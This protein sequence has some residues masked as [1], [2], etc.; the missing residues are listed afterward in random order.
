MADKSLETGVVDYDSPIWGHKWGYQDTEFITLPDG[1]TSVTGSRY[2]I[3]G[4]EMPGFLPFVEEMLDVKLDLNDVIPERED[5]PVTPPNINQPFLDALRGV[6]NESQISLEDKVRLLHSHGQTTADEVYK[7]LYDELDRLCDLVVFPESDEDAA[8]LIQLA[9][10]HNVCLVPYG[11]GTSVSCALQLPASETRM[12]VVVDMRRMNQILWIDKENYRACV[13]A[14]IIGGQLEAELAKEG[15]TSGHEPDS[16]ELST[17]GGWIATN[18]SGMKKNRYGNIEDI[19]ENVTMITPQGVLEQVSTMPRTSI[20]MRLQDLLFGSEGNLGLITKAVIRIHKLPEVQK[21]GSLVFSNFQ[22][23]TDFLYALTRAGV[24]PASIRLLDN[25]QFRF[26]SALKPR[27]TKQQAMMSKIEKYFLLNIKGFDP[28]ELVAA[29]IVMEGTAAEVAYQQKMIAKLA[30]QFK[31]IAGGE[32][33]GRRGYMLTYAIAYIRDYLAQYHI[34]GETYETTVPWDRVMPVIEAVDKRARELHEAANLPGKPYVS[35]RITQLYH[36]GVCIYFTHGFSTKGVAHP[37]RVFGEI[38]HELRRTIIAAGGSISHHHGV[39]KLRKDFMED[40]ISP[41]TA[42][43]LKQVK[44]AH[45][46]QNIFGIR[47]N[48]FA[49]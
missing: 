11:G 21:F 35:P 25:I 48:I 22:L 10:A 26:G 12:I 47:N 41:T 2:A 1:A 36:T 45:D 27:P 13:Q 31:G 4:T 42:V 23:G 49:D 29:T 33:N 34:I 5:K 17:L 3:S 30:K 24:F 18:A 7:V 19:V 28:H 37:D 43:V 38:E 6:L 46:P 40:T 9:I 15:F 39:G 14:G 44:Q 20:G 16:L 8:A 32:G